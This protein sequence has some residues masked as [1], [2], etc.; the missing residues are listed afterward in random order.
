MPS[1]DSSPNFRVT[2][3]QVKSGAAAWLGWMFDGLDM[4]LYTLV[5][6]PFVAELMQSNPAAPEVSV[7][8]SLIQAAFLFGW[9]MGGA[10]F[11]R[12][13]DVLGRSRTLTLTI[14][15][16]AAFTGLSFFA[17]TWWHLLIFRFLAAL[18]IGGEW[19]V[20][21]SL[22]SETWPARWRPWLAAI[23]QSAV[24]LG[25][26]VACFAGWAL[27][28]APYRALFLVGI[29]PALLTLWIRRAVPEPEVWETAHDKA[30]GRQPH[31]RALFGPELRRTTLS[32]VAVCGLGLTAHWAM[33]FWHSAH[34]RTL[35][36][37][38]GWSKERIDALAN[39]ALY[40]LNAGSI[41]GNFLA[42]WLARYIGYRRAIGAIF[43]IYFVLM[44]ITYG[45]VRDVDFIVF[46]LPFL[47]MVQG[48]F[49]LFTMCLPPLFPT[50]LRTTGAGFCYNIGRTLAA[51]GTVIFGLF[52]HVGSGAGAICDH[53]LALFYSAFLFIPAALVSWFWLPESSGE[54][55]LDSRLTP[56]AVPSIGDGVA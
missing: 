16:Y 45:V 31:L 40:L 10:V 34:L 25:V 55:I 52:A 1:F 9:A 43:G 23:L 15:T 13:G 5:A 28:W 22:L 4:H 14:F 3:Q 33:L 8:A 42:G 41:A 26:L 36:R 37:D 29:L 21:A 48:A 46:W 11:G 24:N 20:G 49:A 32:V 38:A 47:G 18:G 12:I 17:H 6:L 30:H 7:K 27:A 39:H 54:R 50:L 35:A 56:A 53:R 51:I 44:M 19:A 2:S